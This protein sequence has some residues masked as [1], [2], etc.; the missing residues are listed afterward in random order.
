VRTVIR[1]HDITAYNAGVT[2]EPVE[3]TVSM[4]FVVRNPRLISGTTP[5]ALVDV[6]MNIC[7]ASFD[8]YGIQARPRPGG[9]TLI[10]LPTFKDA[11]GAW[12]PAVRLPE[13]VHSP[14]TGAILQ[15]LLE[16][17]ILQRK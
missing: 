8:I 13:E 3:E 1:N 14:L 7:G 15:F 11:D 2:A 9:G 12:R 16:E 17:G 5:F 10:Y 6:E 4:Q